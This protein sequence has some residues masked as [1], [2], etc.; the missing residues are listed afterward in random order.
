MIVTPLHLTDD[1]MDSEPIT[2]AAVPGPESKPTARR[3][4]IDCTGTSWWLRWQ[5]LASGHAPAS[6]APAS[7]NPGG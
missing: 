3:R 5:M 6:P 1:T 4:E 2:A 7:G